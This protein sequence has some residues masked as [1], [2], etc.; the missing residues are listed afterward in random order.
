MA[1]RFQAPNIFGAMAFHIRSSVKLLDQGVVQHHG[2]VN[3]ASQWAHRALYCLD[4]LVAPVGYRRYPLGKSS[5]RRL[6]GAKTQPQPVPMARD[7]PADQDQTPRAAPRQTV[8]DGQ[9]KS[10][11]T[12]GDQVAGV[13]IDR[14]SGCLRS[15]PAAPR[16]PSWRRPACRHASP[17]PCSGKRRL[18]ARPETRDAEAEG[19]HCSQTSPSTSLQQRTHESPVAVRMW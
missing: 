16:R 19:G 14:D 3:D 1:W 17:A 13:G 8:G 11:E 15:R 5:P 9:S 10:S 18:L 7:R 6:A 12:A 4:R 2:G